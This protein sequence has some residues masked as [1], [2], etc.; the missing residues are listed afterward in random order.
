MGQSCPALTDPKEYV[1]ALF[2]LARWL[3]TAATAK[4][5]TSDSK[6][7]AS[8]IKARLQ[9][10]TLSVSRGIELCAAGHKQFFLACE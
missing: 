6:W 8:V 10:C 7:A 5:V 1:L 3:A 2:L 9:T 4:P